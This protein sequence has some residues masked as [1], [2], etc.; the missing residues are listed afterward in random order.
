MAEKKRIIIVAGPNGA[1]KTTFAQEFLP[2]AYDCPLFVNADLI[3][4]GLSPFSPQNEA[5]QAGKL[6]L[7]QIDKYV[8][9]GRSFS[10][11]TTLSGQGYA[12][13]IPAW[14]EVGYEVHLIFLMLKT[15]EAALDRVAYRVSQ[16]GHGI[17]DDVVRRRFHKGIANFHKQYKPLVD[18]WYLYDNMGSQPVLVESGGK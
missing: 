15:E 2:I 14:Q 4:D 12:R 3:A 11:E 18:R 7:R 8:A 9:E 17:P 13:R 10:M 6:M 16:G 5:I 1:G